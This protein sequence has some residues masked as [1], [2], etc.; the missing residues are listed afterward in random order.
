[1]IT[2]YDVSLIV[3]FIPAAST[4][5]GRK[6]PFNHQDAM[7]VFRR[8]GILVFGKHIVVFGKLVD[9]FN[10]SKSS[11]LNYDRK[12]SHWIQVL[13][14]SLGADIVLYDVIFARYDYDLEQLRSYI[15]QAVSLN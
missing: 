1:M 2:D 11:W 8:A 15:G 6:R 12:N 13:N 5:E 10:F 9:L 4:F 3:K 7:V 14:R